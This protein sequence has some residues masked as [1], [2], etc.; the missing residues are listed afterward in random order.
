MKK[1]I[2]TSKFG[3]IDFEVY[4]LLYKTVKN[5]NKI[6]KEFKRLDIP[7]SFIL[8]PKEISKITSYKLRQFYTDICCLQLSC[9]AMCDK[10][11][12]SLSDILSIDPCRQTN[13]RRIRIR[14][15]IKRF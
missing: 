8:E 10:D 6:E 14:S 2:S 13:K 12:E 3:E 7:L 9:F 1:S 11:L 5:L 15:R 4:D